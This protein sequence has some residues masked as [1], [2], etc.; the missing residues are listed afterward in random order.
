[1]E[2]WNLYDL[3]RNKLNKQAIRGE[4]LAEGEFHLVVHV[5]IFNSLGQL[6]I[7][8]RQPF[9]QGWSNLWD[10]TCGGSAT[11]GDTSQQAASR[12]LFE[13][14]GIRY[15]FTNIRPQFTSN[16]PRGFDDYYM[17]VEDIELS[18]CTLQYEEVQAVK[19]ASKEEV[20]ALI[21]EQQFIPYYKWLI[22]LLFELKTNY[23]SIKI[24]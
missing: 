16:F 15:D 17:I 3:H 20:L 6:L 14:L 22:D 12:E 5:C 8:Q 19:W 11:A 4:E 10:I 23:G 7:Q 18:E 2:Y 13:E 1:M 24:D 9:K 21:E